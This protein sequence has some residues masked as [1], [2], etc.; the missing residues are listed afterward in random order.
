LGFPFRPFGATGVSIL[1]ITVG[2]ADFVIGLLLLL[3]YALNMNGAIPT[4]QLAMVLLPL[5][6]F[7]F[8]F[9]ILSFSM[10]VSLAVRNQTIPAF[11]PPPSQPGYFSPHPSPQPIREQPPQWVPPQPT[12]APTQYVAQQTILRRTMVWT[13]QLCAQCGN[14]VSAQANYCDNCGAL[15]EPGNQTGEPSAA[16]QTEPYLSNPRAD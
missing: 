16:E 5:A 11:T 8:V 13:E 9:G 14:I 1:Q 15:L 4:A 6:F 10:S 2:I 12:Q 7:T 3:F